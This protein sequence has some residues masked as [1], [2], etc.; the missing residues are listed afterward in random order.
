MFSCSMK[1]KLIKQFANDDET[2]KFVILSM[3]NDDV[4]HNHTQ[5][6]ID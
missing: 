2:L 6:Y 4:E 1:L 3:L 5:F